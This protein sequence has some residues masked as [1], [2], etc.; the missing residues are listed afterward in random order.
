MK[1]FFSICLAVLAFNSLKSQEHVFKS[2]ISADNFIVAPLLNKKSLLVAAERIKYEFGPSGYS[3]YTTAFVI[4]SNGAVLKQKILANASMG[5]GTAN[6]LFTGNALV[7]TTS[8]Y[9]CDQCL[10]G[11]ITRGFSFIL[12]ENLNQLYLKDFEKNTDFSIPI[13]RASSVSSGGNSYVLTNKNV[14]KIDQFGDSLDFFVNDSMLVELMVL[15]N[16]N[17]LTSSYTR[18]FVMDT[19]GAILYSLPT[20]LTLPINS[21]SGKFAS[22]E[23]SNKLVQRNDTLG[24]TDSLNLLSSYASISSLN[25]FNSRIHIFGKD[26]SGK[27]KLIRTDNNLTIIDSIIIESF[28]NIFF[29]KLIPFDTHFLLIGSENNTMSVVGEKIFLFQCVFA[30]IFS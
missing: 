27:Y 24:I 13:L 12:D 17:I 8:N 28:P 1:I 16:D 11:M 15:S 9:N 18:T 6:L 29:K 20:A 5:L 3:Y 30:F 10:T 14:L 26:W 4:D 21:G 7:T 25:Y 22:I 19:L 2:S 23:A